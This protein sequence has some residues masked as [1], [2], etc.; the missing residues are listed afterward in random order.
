M[1]GFVGSRDARVRRKRPDAA[2]QRLE[3]A[4]YIVFKHTQLRWWHATMEQVSWQQLYRRRTHRSHRLN[5][6]ANSE[7]FRVYT[8]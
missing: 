1:E 7:R 4:R 8:T 2:H 3:S 5:D 6:H